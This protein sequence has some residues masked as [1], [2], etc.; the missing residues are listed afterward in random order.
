MG[1]FIVG[2]VVLGIIILAARSVYK[3]RKKGDG[4]GCGCSGCGGSD[5][6]KHGCGCETAERI[7]PPGADTK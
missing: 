6:K 7:N 4:C 5:D 2:A 3:S 1:T